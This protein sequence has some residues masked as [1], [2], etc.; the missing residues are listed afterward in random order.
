MSRK[1][2]ENTIPVLGVSDLERSIEFYRRVLGFE[3]EWNAGHICSVSRDG[4]SI[5]LR[6]EQERAPST[7]WI[8]IDDGS[9]FEAIGQ[10]GVEVIEPP[11]NKP[12][13]YEMTIADPDGNMLWLGAEPRAV[14]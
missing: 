2:V 14:R 11:S 1:Q 9:M 8:G 5:M 6:S 12:W 13:A 10:S 4:S 3:V 7:V